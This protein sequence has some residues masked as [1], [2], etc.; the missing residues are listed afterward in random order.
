[1]GGLGFLSI[2]DFYSYFKV[3]CM[4]LNEIRPFEA[5]SERAR[6]GRLQVSIVYVPAAIAGFNCGC[7]YLYAHCSSLMKFCCMKFRGMSM[8]S[9]K[10]CGS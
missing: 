8:C 1:M 2:L 7:Q 6:H 9:M 4:V 3:C 10:L 5:L